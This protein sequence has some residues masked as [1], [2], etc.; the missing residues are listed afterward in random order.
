M[1]ISVIAA[2]KGWQFADTADTLTRLA[3][4]EHKAMATAQTRTPAH[5]AVVK[6]NTKD[7]MWYVL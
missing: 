3:A 1:N 7:A 4:A 6:A 2:D 5:P